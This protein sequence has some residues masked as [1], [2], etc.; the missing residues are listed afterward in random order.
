MTST[1]VLIVT[2][3]L[4]AAFIIGAAVWFRSRTK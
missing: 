3:I 1:A 2:Y 4:L